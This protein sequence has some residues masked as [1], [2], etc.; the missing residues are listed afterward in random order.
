M[1]REPYTGTLTA[2]L[3]EMVVRAEANAM[4]DE[5]EAVPRCRLPMR[6][7]MDVAEQSR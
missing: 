4:A 1:S 2:D 5:H 6:L 7:V 3:T